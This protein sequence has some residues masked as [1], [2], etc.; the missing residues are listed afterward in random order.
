MSIG[1]TKWQSRRQHV[2]EL[3]TV[4]DARKNKNPV[5]SA[6]CEAKMTHF[7]AVNAIQSGAMLERTTVKSFAEPCT[8]QQSCLSDK[9][10]ANICFDRKPMLSKEAESKLA[11]Y[12]FNR[13]IG[14]DFGKSQFLKLA[15]ELNK[16]MANLS[17]MEVLRK[18]GGCC[19]TREKGRLR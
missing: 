6:D 13:A 8:T 4:C 9:Y 15:G 12:A 10:T 18:N 14:C 2:R 5:R 7:K 1:Y 16:N 11:D 17:R 3:I 19:T